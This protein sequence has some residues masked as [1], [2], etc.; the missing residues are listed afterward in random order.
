MASIIGVWLA[1]VILCTWTLYTAILCSFK[2][3]MMS[4][5]ILLFLT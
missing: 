4:I 1:C 2:R 3:A 5:P